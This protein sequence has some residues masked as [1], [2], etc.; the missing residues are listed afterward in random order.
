MRPGSINANAI[1]SAFSQVKNRIWSV[2]KH[3]SEKGL[4]N[5]L[6]VTINKIFFPEMLKKLRIQYMSL[7]PEFQLTDIQVSWR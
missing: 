1:E 7:N 5:W 3:W 4:L 2:D 6:H